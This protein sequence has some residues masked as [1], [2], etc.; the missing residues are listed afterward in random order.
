MR[1]DHDVLIFEFQCYIEYPKSKDRYLFSKGNYSS[2]RKWLSDSNWEEEYTNLAITPDEG[3]EEL[4]KSLKSMILDL[5]NMFIP[6]ETTSDKPRWK[7][8]EAYRL[9]K[10][11]GTQSN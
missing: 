2:M 6:I 5:R 3:P 11:Q 4:W 9:I 10:K 7:V 8:E 1:H